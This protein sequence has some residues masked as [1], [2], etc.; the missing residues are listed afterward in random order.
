MNFFIKPSFVLWRAAYTVKEYR[1]PYDSHL[2]YKEIITLPDTCNGYISFINWFRDNIRGSWKVVID[3]AEFS[4]EGMKSANGV[5][6]IY[7]SREEDYVLY[8]L[9]WV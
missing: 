6:A 1:A 3:V 9:T 4:E 7:F 2:K 5:Y 8:R